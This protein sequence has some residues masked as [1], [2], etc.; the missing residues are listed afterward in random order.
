MTP[1]NS[2]YRTRASMSMYTVHDEKKTHEVAQRFTAFKEPKQN[3][4]TRHAQ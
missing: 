4:Q 1:M 2:T 3:N